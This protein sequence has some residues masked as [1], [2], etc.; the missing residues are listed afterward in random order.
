MIMQ[1]L[2]H[3]R[4]SVLKTAEPN[5][6]RGGTGYSQIIRTRTTSERTYIARF[7]VQVVIRTTTR[8]IQQYLDREWILPNPL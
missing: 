2:N 8:G 5:I 7:E 4:L 6:K 3:N 1:R